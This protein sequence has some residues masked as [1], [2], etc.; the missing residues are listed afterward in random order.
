MMRRRRRRADRSSA[1]DMVF[2]LLEI[3]EVLWSLVKFVV[4]IP[5]LVLRLFN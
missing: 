4:R 2:G 3:F 5:L 1:G